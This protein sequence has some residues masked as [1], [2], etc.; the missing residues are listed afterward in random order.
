MDVADIA[1]ENDEFNLLEA[2]V[3]SRKPNT[4]TPT[5]R[6]HY[7]D[8]IVAEHQ[9]FCDAECRDEYDRELRLRARGR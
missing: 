2:K 8:E 4:P 7:C 3:S 6:C 9:P 1:S 5:G